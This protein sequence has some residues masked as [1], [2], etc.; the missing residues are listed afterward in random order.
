[1]EA[2]DA[3][4]PKPATVQDHVGGAGGRSTIQDKT[5][6]ENDTIR[7]VGI[8]THVHQTLVHFKF[9]PNQQDHVYGTVAY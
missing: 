9:I 4:V 8:S 5:Y 7:G 2:Q 1:M 3:I 6:Q